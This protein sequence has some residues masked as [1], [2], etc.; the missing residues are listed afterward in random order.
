MTYTFKK[1]VFFFFYAFSFFFLPNTHRSERHFF[2]FFFIQ[3]KLFSL[4]LDILYNIFKFEEG[5]I[6]FFFG[7]LF[8]LFNCL[9]VKGDL[10]IIFKQF[11]SSIT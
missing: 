2:F 7:G 5:G 11:R 6:G 9:R 10:F 4:S 3:N 1:N 8:L